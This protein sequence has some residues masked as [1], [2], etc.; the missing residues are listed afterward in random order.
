M[1]EADTYFHILFIVICCSSSTCLLKV[2]SSRI[3]GRCSTIFYFLFS[4]TQPLQWSLCPTFFQSII[5]CSRFPSDAFLFFFLSRPRLGNPRST[6]HSLHPSSYC[7]ILFPSLRLPEIYLPYM[8]LFFL[9]LLVDFRI[10]VRNNVLLKQSSELSNSVTLS[11]PRK[12]QNMRS[13]RN[14]RSGRGRERQR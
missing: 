1:K 14:N 8:S 10:L 12:V 11:I 13:L 6:F 2:L 4:T 7:L 9:C 3:H 5:G